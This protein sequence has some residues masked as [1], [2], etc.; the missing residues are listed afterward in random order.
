[1]KKLIGLCIVAV[2]VFGMVGTGMADSWT[3]Q[4]FSLNDYALGSDSSTSFSFTVPSLSGTF[5]SAQLNV[6]VDA[7]WFFQDSYPLYG[8]FGN[9]PVSTYYTANSWQFA[10]WDDFFTLDYAATINVLSTEGNAWQGGTVW[11][12]L[13]N[14]CPTLYL[15]DATL[16]INYDPGSP[17]PE[18]ASL[19]LLGTGLAGFAGYRY[20]RRAK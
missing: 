3:S 13:T 16:T 20:R 7:G 6:G 18:P 9:S 14:N 1:M 11:M 2:A 8:G 17:V 5:T 10:E 4:T 12:T 19:L 15:D